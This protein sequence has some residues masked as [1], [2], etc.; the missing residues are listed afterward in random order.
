MA[1][2]MSREKGDE[3]LYNAYV[4]SVPWELDSHE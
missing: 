3:T 4:A 1:N 2:S